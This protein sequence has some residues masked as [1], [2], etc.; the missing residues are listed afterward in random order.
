MRADA[1]GSWLK[2]RLNWPPRLCSAAAARR[3]P[4]AMLPAMQPCLVDVAEP[5]R[6][7]PREEGARRVGALLAGWI[8]V[9]WPVKVPPTARQ[10]GGMC[11]CARL[12]LFNPL[13]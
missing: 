10:A 3:R 6:A 2:A 7:V 12:A 11:P 9:Q 13:D 4:L 8:P 1:G 5:L